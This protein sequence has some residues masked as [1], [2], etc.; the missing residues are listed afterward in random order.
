MQDIAFSLCEKELKLDFIDLLHLHK[1]FLSTN[2][3]EIYIDENPGLPLINPHQFVSTYHSIIDNH[4]NE[5]IMSCQKLLIEK[6]YLFFILNNKDRFYELYTT[7]YIELFT[8]IDVSL[9]EEH[10]KIQMVVVDAFNQIN[11]GEIH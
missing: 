5:Q 6:K 2:N 7:K 1:D 8:T 4:L 9:V 10:E 3:A 11:Q